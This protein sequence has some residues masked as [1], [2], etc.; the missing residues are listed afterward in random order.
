MT[1]NNRLPL[2][3]SIIASNEEENLQRSFESLQG[4]AAEIIFVYNNYLTTEL[5]KT[6]FLNK[7][8]DDILKKLYI[9]MKFYI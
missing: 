4:I 1:K 5:E 3:V 7:I 8:L 6:N 2:S 9:M